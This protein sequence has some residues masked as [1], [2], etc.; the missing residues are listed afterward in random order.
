[1][2]FFLSPVFRSFA[3]PLLLFILLQPLQASVTNQALMSLLKALEANGTIDSQT[4]EL[5]KSIAEQEDKS[6]AS[7]ENKHTDVQIEKIVEAKVSEIQKKNDGVTIKTKG[8]FEITS[9]D[10]DFKFRVGGRIQADTA[11]YAEGPERNFSNGTELRR[12]RLFAQG[13]LWH[14]WKY[15]LQY[16]FTGSG[17]DG[18]QDAYIDYSGKKALSVRFGH[19]KEPFGLQNMTSSKYVIFTERAL[20][21]AFSPGRNIGVQIASNGD[22]WSLSTG[23]FGQTNAIRKNEGTNDEGF[24]VSTRATFSPKFGESSRLHLGTALSY[25]YRNKPL[26][27]LPNI[28][29]RGVRFNERP[30]SHLANRQLVDTGMIFGADDS[31]LLGLETALIS[32]SF[33]LE[34]EYNHIHLNRAD[35]FWSS[36]LGETD[37]GFSGYYI[38]GSWF[39]T[40]ES[41]AYNARKGTFGRPALNSIVGKGGIG[42]W[43]LA[44]RFSSLDL[45]DA[46]VIGGEAKNIT[47]GLN[48]YTTPNI[49]LSA[50]YVNVLDSRCFST[51]QQLA[52]SPVP[53]KLNWCNSVDAFQLRAQVEF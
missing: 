2:T 21:N 28:S 13:S 30:E 34:G 52:F 44:L 16:D 35:D 5:V 43:Q 48:W 9:N 4:Y 24:S 12:V 29:D 50:N 11:I 6:I 32:G 14:H 31:I 47:V 20:I 53:L 39:I 45:N 26:H 49:R 27:S 46:D 23:L 25:R 22:N 8:K 40:G 41:V 51:T 37:V 15:K 3:S 1:M 33:S 7:A 38:Q 19:F 17:I 36:G 18:L 42:A 10:G